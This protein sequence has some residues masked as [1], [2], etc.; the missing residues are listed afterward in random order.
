MKSAGSPVNLSFQRRLT[1]FS[2]VGRSKPSLIIPGKGFME[3]LEDRSPKTP[4]SM[5]EYSTKSLSY[6]GSQNQSIVFEELGS[7]EGKI[8]DINN[9]IQWNLSVL[10]DRQRKTRELDLRLREIQEKTLTTDV[11]TTTELTKCWDCRGKCEVI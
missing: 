8:K 2:P 3:R 6:T 5:H 9:K 7:L 10:Q 1:S 11:S 4:Y